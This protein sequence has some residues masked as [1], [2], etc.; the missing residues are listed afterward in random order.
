[1][2]KTSAIKRNLIE[3][4]IKPIKLI[5]EAVKSLLPVLVKTIKEVLLVKNR[6]EAIGGGSYFLGKYSLCFSAR[7]TLD[8]RE[9]ARFRETLSKRSGYRG[10][11]SSRANRERM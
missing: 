7:L 4:L 1:M 3:V 10:G 2:W 9:R 8:V 6:L 11:S 5:S